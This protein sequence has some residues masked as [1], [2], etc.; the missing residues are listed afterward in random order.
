MAVDKETVLLVAKWLGIVLNVVTLG[1]C[2]ATFR[3]QWRLIR[4]GYKAHKPLMVIAALLG[5]FAGLMIF[6]RLVQI[7]G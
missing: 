2:I 5:I 4:D 1:F 3:I 7:Y 6:E